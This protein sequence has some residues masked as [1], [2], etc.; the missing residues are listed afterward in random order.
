M[1]A[2]S[3][4]LAYVAAGRLDAFWEVGDDPGDWLAGSLLV[5]EAGG[6]AT[7]LAGGEMATGEGILAGAPAIHGH[8]LNAFR[9]NG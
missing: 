5:T 8:L 7:T 3:L 1:A 4:Q 2:V 9:K 6:R